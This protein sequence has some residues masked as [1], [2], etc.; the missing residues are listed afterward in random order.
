MDACSFG[1]FR[2]LECEFFGNAEKIVEQKNDFN[3]FLLNK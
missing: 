2:L 3:L 1:E